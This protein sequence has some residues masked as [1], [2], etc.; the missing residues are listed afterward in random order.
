MT[1]P[2]VI[3]GAGQAGGRA[4]EALRCAGHAGS[5]TLVGEEPHPPYERPALSKDLLHEG[6]RDR[7]AWVRPAA[8]YEANGVNLLRG[9]RVVAVDRGRCRIALDDGTQTEYE[10]LI[11]TTGARARPLQV[12][13]ADHPVVT[14]L[15][16][17][18]DSDRLQRRLLS[19]AHVI[20]IGAGFIGLEAAAAARSRGCAVTVLEVAD[21]PLLRCI[22]AFIGQHYAELHRSHGVVV[23]TGTRVLG[24][25]DENGRARVLTGNGEV[26]PADVV[27]LGLGIIPN[28]EPARAAGLEVDDGIVVDEFGR[29]SD[30]R[31]YAAG[32]VSRHFNPLLGRRLRLESWQNA[33][34]QAIAVA[35]NVLGAARPYAQVPWFWSDQFG[36]NLQMSGLPE[37]ADEVIRRG[38][39]GGGPA[40]FLHLRQDRLAAAIGL[41][42]PRELRIAQQIIAL[43]G[44]ADRARLVDEA[45]GMTRILADL[46]HSARAA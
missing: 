26:P 7:I 30:P 22:P 14:C 19:G 3:I 27:V 46:K 41:N 42:C 13:G 24:I 38:H 43:G 21:L 20:V 44:A 23:R 17:L 28:V 37:P 40:L 29:T 36:V 12:P 1:G 18:E 9:R 39:L 10:T 31:I 32:D 2:I 35:R 6:H 8:W 4:A 11:L 5:I 25:A 34:N 45:I 33:Q 16:T 15:R